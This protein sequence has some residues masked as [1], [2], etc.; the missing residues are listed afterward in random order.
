[1]SEAKDP[2]ILKR[3]VEH[4]RVMVSGDTDFG[5]LIGE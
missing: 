1:M 3:A 2:E 5:E 4:S